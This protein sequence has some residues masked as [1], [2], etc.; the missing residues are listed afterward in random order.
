MK[1]DPSKYFYLASYSYDTFMSNDVM[2]NLLFQINSG[3]LD[4]HKK[5][6]DIV[7]FIKSKLY[8]NNPQP[9]KVQKS[10]TKYFNFP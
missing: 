6:I 8:G 3:Q 5:N 1:Y 2:R 10:N 9:S 4:N 7:D